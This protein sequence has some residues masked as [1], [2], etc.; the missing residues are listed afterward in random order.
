M[1]KIVVVL[2]FGVFGHCLSAQTEY[3]AVIG[4]RSVLMGDSVR[5]VRRDLPYLSPGTYYSQTNVINGMQRLEFIEEKNLSQIES[6]RTTV[7][8]DFYLNRLYRIEM[9]IGNISNQTLQNN[10]RALR[11]IYG[12]ESRSEDKRDEGRAGLRSGNMR[13][14]FKTPGNNMLN[15]VVTMYFH[16]VR[17]VSER[18][19]QYNLSYIYSPVLNELNTERERL[20]SPLSYELIIPNGI[21]SIQNGAHLNNPPKNVIHNGIGYINDILYIGYYDVII[22]SVIIPNS[23]KTIGTNAF[24]FN[25]I[26]SVT[27]PNSVTTIGS[28]AFDNNNLTRI[29]IPNSVTE[30]GEGAF[31]NNLITDATIPNNIIVIEIRLFNN[32]KLNKI[33]IPNGVTSIGFEAFAHNQLTSI[34]IPN[35]VTKIGG[36]AFL[37]NKISNIT[38]GANVVMEYEMGPSGRTGPFDNKFSDF[39]STNGSKAGNYIFANGRWSIN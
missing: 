20:K 36:L 8:A 18:T 24:S 1:K 38:I 26:N 12:N 14:E 5:N 6:V 25:K 7:T 37:D 21:T 34:V 31:A 17:G 4:D 22:T 9:F 13:W 27:I 10:I 30:I 28:R 29:V 2:L 39:Y 35:S 15:F 3:E 32:N 16:E 23:V 33:I 11:R 19:I